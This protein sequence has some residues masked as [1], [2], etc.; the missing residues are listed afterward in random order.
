MTTPSKK[1]DTAP[2]ASKKGFAGERDKEIGLRVRMGRIIRDVS[3]EKL[4]EELGISFQQVQKYER[5]ANRISAARVQDIAEALS[6][7][8]LFFH[9][10]E[11]EQAGAA[12]FGEEG[13]APFGGA[14]PTDGLTGE[15]LY[16]ERE[17]MDLLRLYFDLP[18]GPKR[19][20]F[21]RSVQQHAKDF[22]KK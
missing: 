7:P 4:A 10:A 12:G 11:L 22:H 20:A 14:K 18:P 13:Q 16:N 9:G 2:P 6:L 1:V 21:V 19:T 15:D 8:I 5:G 17:A 3:Q